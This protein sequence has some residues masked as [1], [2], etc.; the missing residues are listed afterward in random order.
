MLNC[1]RAKKQN[2]VVDNNTE[3]AETLSF[4]EFITQFSADSNFQL[5]HIAFP[6]TVFVPKNDTMETENDTTYYLSRK[7]WKFIDLADASK[8]PTVE[9]VMFEKQKTDNGFELLV[10]GNDSGIYISYFFEKKNDM[11]ILTGMED[12][13]M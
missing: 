4:D 8:Y 1:N 6:L 7:D 11:W 13:S 12:R 9:K 5:Q 10:K 2:T 3:I